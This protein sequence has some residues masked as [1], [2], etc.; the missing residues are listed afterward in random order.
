MADSKELIH[1][2]DT[3]LNTK[4][5]SFCGAKWGNS[6]LWLNSGETASCH[7]PPVHKIDVVQIQEDPSKLHTTDHKIKMREMMQKGEKPSECD[8]CWKVEGMGPNFTSD[9]VFKSLQFSP[10]EMQEWYEAPPEA[11]IVPPTIEVM[12]DRTCNFACS[13]CNANFST[14]WAKDIKKFGHYEGETRGMN[15]YK[16]D[17]SYNNN[18]DKITNPYIE[19]WWKWWPELTQ[20][21]RVLRITGGEPLMSDDVW[22]LFDKVAEEGHRFEVGVNTNLGA[23][24]ALID[25]LIKKS[26]DMHRL[27]IF[28]SM[29]SIGDQAEYMRDK[30]DYEHWK[31][32]VE[33][34][35]EESNVKRLVVM[36][37][38][39]ALCVFNVTSFLDQMLAWKQKYKKSIG[40]SINFLRFPAFMNVTV[41]PDHIRNEAHEEIKLWYEINKDSPYL[42]SMEKGDIERLIS[43]VNVIETPHSYDTDIEK[44][45]KDFKRFYTQYDKRR[46]K[47]I[48]IFPENFL[49]WYDT[50]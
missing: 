2:R 40:I 1:F 7:L 25:R 22:K 37:T 6:T 27:T 48:R 8:Y 5:P 46:D 31:N 12:F 11:R 23:K 9:R 35:F 29:E 3:V 47:S 17:G 19:A 28:T 16:H 43:Y 20:K 49:Q 24:K 30:L 15:A 41:L 18:H 36:M 38:I 50:L 45:R 44:N 10:E 33:R 13:Y 4:S 26:H 32:N 42:N 39:N 21:L 14:E 34:I